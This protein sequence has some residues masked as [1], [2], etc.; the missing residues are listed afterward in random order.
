MNRIF[1]LLIGLVC[2]TALFS[3]EKLYIHKSDLMTL[4]APVL[5]MDSVYFSADGSVIYFRVN[6]STAHYTLTT[7]D[8]LTFGKNSDTIWVNYQ[9]TKASVINPLAFEGVRVDVSGAD[10]TVTSTTETQDINFKLSGNATNG[11]FKIYSEKRFNLLLNG[12]SITHADGPAINIQS[13]KKASVTLVN[14]TS[15]I[16][17]DGSTYAA[18]ATG[19]DGEAEDQGAAFFGEDKMVFAGSGSLTINGKGNDKNALSSKSIE[20][21][22]GTLTIAGAVKD[23][24]HGKN[25]II[26]SGGTL[27]VTSSGD[28]IDGDSGDLLISGGSV[29]INN[30]VAGANGI[31][32]DST[33]EITGGTVSI[34]VSGNGAKGI[35][36]AQIMT[37]SGGDITVNTG[38]GVALEA[39]GSGY[40][41]AYCTAVKCDSNLIVKG[42]TLIIKGTGVANKGISSD[43]NMTMESGS[44]NITL[45]GNGGTYKNS[46]G[47]TDSYNSTCITADADIS[48]LGC[49]VTAANSGTGGKGITA[50]GKLTVGSAGSTPTV[51]VTTSGTKFLVSGSDYTKSKAIKSEGALAIANGTTTITSN[52]KGLESATSITIGNATVVITQSV[53]GMEAPFITVN[54]DSIRIY[55]S[56]DGFNATKGNGG[57]SNDGSCLTINGGYVYVNTTTGDGLDSNGN[58]VIAGGKI[59][60]HGP[61]S[62]PEVGMDYNGTCSVTGG[63]LVISGTDSNMTQA[64]GTTSSVYS[65]KIMSRS[66]FSN[67]TL[68]H[69]QDESGKDIL[70]FQPARSYY[71]IVFASSSLVSGAKYYVYTGGS[72]SGSKADGLYSGGT[73]SGGTQKTSFTISGKVTSVSLN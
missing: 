60:V 49:S 51:K 6:D 55:A 9:G 40:N 33:L 24:I 4:G 63:I 46:S 29:T 71:S 66:S 68:F 41:P 43:C 20:I 44:V 62:N 70:T 67:S 1:S 3:Q 22:N 14:G 5:G 25:G 59:I 21:Q 13:E 16:L 31:V 2:C 69:I 53:E 47:T 38:G 17:T 27:K 28:A 45:S 39:S 7:I 23:G 32:C 56:D 61:Q 52:D 15:S 72:S 35:R 36:S 64:P 37:L 54:G 58:I 12:V 50:D 10:V 11:M 48:I 8:S 18:A 26:I 57:E 73:Y 42:A 30:T 19:D 65:V 34:T